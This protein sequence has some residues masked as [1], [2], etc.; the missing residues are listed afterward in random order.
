MKIIIVGA[1]PKKTFSKKY[2]LNPSDYFI[3]LDAGS[4]E[5]IKRSI[6]PDISIGDFDSTKDFELIRKNSH[7]T[8]VYPSKKDETDLELALRL[9]DQLKGSENLSIDIY[10]I[11][12]GRLDHEYNAYMLLSKYSKYKLK[13]IDDKNEVIYLKE[14]SECALWRNYKYF[15]IFANTE[16]I[17]SIKNAKYCLDNVALNTNDTYTISN[18]K[19]DNETT[20]IIEVKK[21]GV[22]LF[23]VYE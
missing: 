12:G 2:H 3:G 9:L 1:S 16:S 15:S 23:T 7:K 19:I 21:G 5:I 11:T 14:G 22:L 13:I 10:D 8:I 6:V 4:L 20:P 18:E 17:V